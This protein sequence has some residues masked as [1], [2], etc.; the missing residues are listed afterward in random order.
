MPLA[1][2]PFARTPTDT[3]V[4][5]VRATVPAATIG[6]AGIPHNVHCMSE[7][8]MHDQCRMLVGRVIVFGCR[9]ATDPHTVPFLFHAGILLPLTSPSSTYFVKISQSFNHIVGVEQIIGERTFPLPEKGFQYCSIL[10]AVVHQ[11]EQARSHVQNLENTV[12]HMQSGIDE[13]RALLLASQNSHPN[14]NPNPNPNS[15]PPPQSSPA[16]FPNNPQ[17]STINPPHPAPSSLEDSENEP[18]EFIY[19]EDATDVLAW[20]NILPDKADDLIRDLRLKYICGLTHL[21]GGDWLQESFSRLRGWINTTCPGWSSNVDM[22]HLGNQL[23]K[24]LRLHF[25]FVKDGTSRTKMNKELNQ[26]SKDSMERANARVKMQSNR[27]KKNA[28]KYKKNG[29][30]KYNSSYNSRPQTG[31][32]KVGH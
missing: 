13:L 2:Q 3:F 27:E 30:K 10:D 9:R 16:S 25:F 4:D 28:Y 32:E 15:M 12:Y 17:P 6:E 14:P 20:N 24:D 11:T 31:N 23:L 7:T 26:M 1:K 19:P 18:V 5:A 8:R 29:P 21:S 22:I